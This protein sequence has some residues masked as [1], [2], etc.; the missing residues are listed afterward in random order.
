MI[1]YGDRLNTTELAS[2]LAFLFESNL[3]NEVATGERPTPVCIWGTHGL[4]KTASVVS[5]ARA[6]G[7]KLAYCAPAQFEE[8]GDLHGLPM[9]VDPDPCRM[10]DE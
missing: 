10:G 6:R 9:K 3:A 7:W 4:G 5:F 1:T 8:I 2:L